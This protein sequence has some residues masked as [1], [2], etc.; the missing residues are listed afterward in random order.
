VAEPHLADPRSIRWEAF[1]APALALGA[2]AVFAFPMRVGAVRLGVVSLYQTKSGDLSEEQYGDA[3]TVADVVTD[4]IVALQAAAPLGDL[5]TP[6]DVIGSDRVQLH[7]ATGIVAA[8][9]GIGAGEVSGV[10]WGV[11]SPAGER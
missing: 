8:H 7:Q 6:L 3:R 10:D 11:N 9:L 1:T 4:A 5:A 2:A